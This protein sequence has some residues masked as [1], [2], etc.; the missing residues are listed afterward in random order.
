MLNEVKSFLR[1]LDETPYEILEGFRPQLFDA[2]GPFSPLMPA[3]VAYRANRSRRC[4][5]PAPHPP[6]ES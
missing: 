4:P 3:D 5:I 6:A 2:V 1:T